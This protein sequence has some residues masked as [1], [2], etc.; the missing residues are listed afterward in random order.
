MRVLTTRGTALLLA[1]TA[2]ITAVALPAFAGVTA[3]TVTPTRELA[4]RVTAHAGGPG[5]ASHPPVTAVRAGTVVL[6]PAVA[7]VREPDG[8][9]R[10]YR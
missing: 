4:T 8:T 10:R 5:T 7:Y 3:H 6:G 2:G 1:V 9:V